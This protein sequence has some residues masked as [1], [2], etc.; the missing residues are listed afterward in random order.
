MRDCP[1]RIRWDCCAGFRY[2]RQKELE[3][4]NNQRTALL[5]IMIAC[6]LALVAI[7]TRRK[8]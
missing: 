4:M 6:L 3:T 8:K 1:G 2:G 5:F 7:I